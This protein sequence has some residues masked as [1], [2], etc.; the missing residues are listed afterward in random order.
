MSGQTVKENANIYRLALPAS[1]SPRR[2]REFKQKIEAIERFNPTWAVVSD[3]ARPGEKK[4]YIVV[5]KDENYAY[6]RA[7][8][9]AKSHL[10]RAIV[11]GYGDEF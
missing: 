10:A 2:Q 7:L 1:A 8:Y 9:L 5:R 4:A 11:G 3:R 6:R